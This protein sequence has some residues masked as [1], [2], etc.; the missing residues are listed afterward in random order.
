MRF[1]ATVC[2]FF[3]IMYSVT[4][5]NFQPFRNKHKYQFSYT[6]Y[7]QNWIRSG[8]I[9]GIQVD[10]AKLIGPDS[11]FYFNKFNQNSVDNYW[12]NSMVKKSGGEYLF[13]ITNNTQ[14]DTLIIKTQLALGS[15][16]T[17]TLKNV[18]YTITYDHYNPETVLTNHT[19]FV[20]TYIVENTSGFKDSI[21]ISENFGLV[22]SFPFSD[23]SYNFHKHL[24]LTYIF[25]SKTGENKINYFD[26][27]NYELGD[28]LS[29][30][31]D[32]R[33]AAGYPDKTGVDIYKVISKTVSLNNDTVAYLFSK[34]HIDAINSGNYYAT[35][36]YCKLVV[37]PWSVSGCF[38]YIDVL[39]F[40]PKSA[41]FVFASGINGLAVGPHHPFEYDRNYSFVKGLGLEKFTR[42]G[43]YD[44]E[45]ILYENI[46]HIKQS[47][48]DDNC[49][50]L[51]KIL[52]TKSL[53]AS[54]ANLV[55]APNPFD[56]S[57]LLNATDL[58]VGDWSIRI[59]SALG[60]EVYN[61]KITI[62][63]SN[64]QI[65]LFNLPALTSGI[66]FLSLENENQVYSQKIVKQ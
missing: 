29:Y 30:T 57:V 9:H 16:W 39:S 50:G 60:V 37:T 49:D 3:S 64:Q 48:T 53:H 17:F 63:S 46:R 31:P 54:S 62:S 20:Q 45:D 56:Q 12:G 55:V 59:V 26:Y 28:M 34:C 21:K 43:G 1:F 27:F 18:L 41:Y 51:E 32:Y 35:K 22:Y 7:F 8:L 44:Y 4:A 10:S 40:P 14:N 36:T 2:V 11:V 23:E 42:G 65:D 33:V 24:N 15:Q 47:N 52:S 13:L 66:Y 58:S 6:G 38:P 25:N 61:S 19:D 5:Q